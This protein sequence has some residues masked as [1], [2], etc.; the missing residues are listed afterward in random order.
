MLDHG[1]INSSMVRLKE[2]EFIF[3]YRNYFNRNM[4]RY[5][6]LTRLFRDCLKDFFFELQVELF[7]LQFVL[8]HTTSLLDY[9]EEGTLDKLVPCEKTIY[10]IL[11][12]R[13]NPSQ[14]LILKMHLYLMSME[15]I[16][17]FLYC[18]DV[19]GLS[20]LY[21][22]NYAGLLPDLNAHNLTLHARGSA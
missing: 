9:N 16:P 6:D 4:V 20:D 3:K 5:K 13:L 11:S 22:Q 19:D 10:T 12:I 18:N 1:A 15:F 21:Y 17:L 2:E 8:D 7:L 14:D